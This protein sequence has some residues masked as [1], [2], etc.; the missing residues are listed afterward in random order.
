MFNRYLDISYLS[1]SILYWAIGLDIMGGQQL[2][3]SVNDVGSC[4]FINKWKITI[5]IYILMS[6]PN[7]PW[8]GHTQYLEYSNG[9]TGEQH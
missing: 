3:L 6:L 7:L 2:Y 1:I 8:R 9:Y 5:I 4:P